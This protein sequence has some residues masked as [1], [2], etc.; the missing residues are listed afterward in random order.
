MQ[1]LASVQAR[2][3]ASPWTRIH[4]IFALGQLGVFIVSVVLLALYL[5]GVVGFAAVHVSVIIKFALMVGAVVTGSLWEHD[6]FGPWWFAREFLLEDVMT[7]IVMAA[8]VLYFVAVFVQHSVGLA[9]AILTVAYALYALN[10]IQYVIS[11]ASSRKNAVAES[12][13]IAA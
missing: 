6:V 12:E 2:K 13:P 11:H 7:A 9:V 10:V 8:H 1:P 5:A 3:N 4:P